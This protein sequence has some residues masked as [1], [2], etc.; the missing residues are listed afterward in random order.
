MAK[1]AKSYKT[2][3]KKKKRTQKMTNPTEQGKFPKNKCIHPNQKNKNW[4]KISTE[5]RKPRPV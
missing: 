1:A 2:A 5:N 4:N 3:K